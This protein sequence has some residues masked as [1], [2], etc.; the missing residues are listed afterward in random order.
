VT[1][2]GVVVN[3]DGGFRFVPGSV[4]C[5][6]AVAAEAGHTLVHAEFAAPPALD[7]GFARIE[8]HLRAAGRPITALC[9]IDLRM[10]APLDV[11]DFLSFNA[12]YIAR[13]DRWQLRQG[14]HIPL[15]RTNVAPVVGPPAEATVSGFTYTLPGGSIAPTF[16][17]SGTAELPD[18]QS[19]PHGLTRF[20]DTSPDAIADKARTVAELLSGILADLGVG[21][22]PATEIHVYSAHDSVTAVEQAVLPDFKI[23]PARGVVWHNTFPPVTHLEIE[24]DLRR[25]GQQLLLPLNRFR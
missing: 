15:T 16:L 14:G 24:I 2:A 22:D 9:G 12:D 4:F 19:Y 8:D 21:W 5:S 7:D 25:L 6:K 23:T 13:L 1:G 17:V 11:R 20:G 3:R 18:G 10:P